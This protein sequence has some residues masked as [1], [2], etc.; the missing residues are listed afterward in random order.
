MWINLKFTAKD[1]SPT[2]YADMRGSRNGFFWSVVDRAIRL[3][4]KLGTN[5]YPEVMNSHEKIKFNTWTHVATT[6]DKKT[7]GLSLYIDGKK[8]GHASLWQGIDYFNKKGAPAPTCAI[9]NMP[10]FL[11]TPKYQ[12]YG[13]VMDLYILN[14]ASD[15]R[16]LVDLL[17]G[18]FRCCLSKVTKCFKYSRSSRKQT[19]SGRKKRGP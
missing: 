19:H 17:G 10:K 16:V 13:S 9:G 14:I 7:D 15:E 5:D 2:F 1:K 3:T 11:A 6:F 18:T 4:A 8:Q 12:F